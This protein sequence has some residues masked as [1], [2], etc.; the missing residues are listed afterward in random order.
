VGSPVYPDYTTGNE[1]KL[2][3]SGSAAGNTMVGTVVG[4]NIFGTNT[5]TVKLKGT[6]ALVG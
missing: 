3:V 4:M 6:D 1:G 5:I 2:T